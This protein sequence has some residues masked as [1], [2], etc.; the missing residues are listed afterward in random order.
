MSLSA[1]FLA[2]NYRNYPMF[3]NAKQ[4]YFGKNRDVQKQR[5]SEKHVFVHLKIIIS[6]KNRGSPKTKGVRKHW[7]ITVCVLV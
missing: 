5:V 6:L 4:N 3:S 7:V 2:F 1:N